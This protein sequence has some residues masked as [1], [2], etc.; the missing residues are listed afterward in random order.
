[1]QNKTKK[2][3]SSTKKSKNTTKRKSN[4]MFGDLVFGGNSF[5]SGGLSF[6]GTSFGGT[7][8]GLSQDLDFGYS[9]MIF[10]ERKPQSKKSTTAKSTSKKSTSKRTTKSVNRKR[11]PAKT[12]SKTKRAAKKIYHIKKYNSLFADA[13]Q[14]TTTSIAPIQ[15][16]TSPTI[17]S[18]LSSSINAQNI[19]DAMKNTQLSNSLSNFSNSGLVGIDNR[20]AQFSDVALMKNVSNENEKEF[21]QS[22]DDYKKIHTDSYLNSE[23]ELVNKL[24]TTDTSNEDEYKTGYNHIDIKGLNQRNDILTGGAVDFEQLNL[25]KDYETNKNNLDKDYIK[26]I[27]SDFSKLYSETET[28]YN[29]LENDYNKL[30]NDLND[31]YQEA[32][33]FVDN[34]METLQLENDAKTAQLESEYN[35]NKSNIIDNLNDDNNAKINLAYELLPNSTFLNFSNKI[36]DT[37]IEN[38]AGEIEDRISNLEERNA[39]LQQFITDYTKNNTINKNSQRVKNI[40]M[41]ITKNTAQIQKLNQN[42]DKYNDNFSEIDQNLNEAKENMSE[43][44]QNTQNTYNHW[45]NNLNS[46]LVSELNTATTNYENDLNKLSESRQ[47]SRDEL[48]DKYKGILSSQVKDYDANKNSISARKTRAPKRKS[49]EKTYPN[50]AEMRMSIYRMF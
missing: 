49:N 8:F 20:S 17:S 34:N 27:K 1:M 12:K 41:E 38:L 26:D 25:I 50:L 35:T 42:L 7:S 31:K 2:S 19:S 4:D 32:K 46:N 14:L 5:D 39:K 11:A 44:Y 6:G 33:N 40:K 24:N 37:H 15:T 21:K 10:G 30:T 22:F 16:Q 9:D 48:I 47:Q 23:T 28:K 13:T 18:S 3:T 43:N 45:L 29:N 36:N